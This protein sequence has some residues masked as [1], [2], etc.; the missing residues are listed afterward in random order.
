MEQQQISKKRAIELIVNDNFKTVMN[1]D[2][3]GSLLLREILNVGFDG[4]FN[5]RV[6]HLQI[7]L[8]N[9]F[10]DGVYIINNEL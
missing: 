10:G 5:T 9:R 7:E 6:Y 3:N 4:W 2:E 1:D 8:D